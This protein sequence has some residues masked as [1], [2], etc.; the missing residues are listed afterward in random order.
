MVGIFAGLYKCRF[1]YKEKLRSKK[2]KV[3]LFLLEPGYG[4]QIEQ[5]SLEAAYFSQ[6]KSTES[7]IFEFECGP[8]YNGF[9]RE[10]RVLLFGS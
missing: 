9:T 8:D 1:Y 5:L 6:K 7:Y 3:T 4:C 10:R 2:K